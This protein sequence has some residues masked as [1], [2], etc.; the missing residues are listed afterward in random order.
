MCVFF[1]LFFT[2]KKER[3]RNVSF[4]HTLQSTSNLFSIDYMICCD[5]AEEAEEAEHKWES[6][7]LVRKPA[8]MKKG[9]TVCRRFG[10]GVKSSII[11]LLFVSILHSPSSYPLVPLHPL[12]CIRF[13]MTA[14]VIWSRPGHPCIISVKSSP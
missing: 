3:K 10:E 13:M 2:S 4:H 9:D 12:R 7:S 1:L 11:G 8:S 5:C 14:R 6:V